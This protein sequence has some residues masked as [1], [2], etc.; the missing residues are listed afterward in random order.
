MSDA[1]SAFERD[2]RDYLRSRAP[3]AG[4]EGAELGR[5]REPS[6][7]PAGMCSCQC[8][9]SCSCTCPC[10]CTIGDLDAEPRA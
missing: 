4:L 9:C 8:D 5:S 3:A 6:P 1:L 10:G 2:Y 7:L